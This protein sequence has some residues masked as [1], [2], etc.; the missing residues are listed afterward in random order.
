[1]L[2]STAGSTN[3]NVNI[4]RSVS[5]LKTVF[6]T[7]DNVDRNA[8]GLPNNADGLVMKDFNSFY[9]PMQDGAYHWLRELQYQL[10]IGGKFIP[11]YPVRSLSSSIL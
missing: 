11:E 10:K 3:I 4:A 7:L 6:I 2:Q 1:M 9:H 8:K 5:R